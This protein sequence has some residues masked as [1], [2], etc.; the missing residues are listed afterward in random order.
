MNFSITSFPKEILWHHIMAPHYNARMIVSLSRTNKDWYRELAENFRD[1]L[2]R[3]TTSPCPTTMPE[4]LFKLLALIDNAR[5]TMNKFIYA[6]KRINQVNEDCK[7]D[8]FI[9]KKDINDALYEL[10]QLQLPSLSSSIF[11]N[12][13]IGDDSN[14]LVA[15]HKLDQTTEA[16]LSK[17]FW[18]EIYFI[19]CF[20]TFFGGAFIG[21]IVYP[22]IQLLMHLSPLESIGF[23]ISILYMLRSKDK[24]L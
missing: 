20:I 4:S 18:Y 24:K 16:A 9:D 14:V 2:S 13:S 5:G 22:I 19:G 23:S 8:P 15:L 17:C 12:D 1:L 7:D 10:K 11:E 6:D 21:I 3:F